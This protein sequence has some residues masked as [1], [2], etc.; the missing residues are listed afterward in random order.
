M[1]RSA[2]PL[3]AA[4]ALVAALPATAAAKKTAD[5]QFAS[6]GKATSPGAVLGVGADGTFEDFPFTIAADDQDGSVTVG[7]QW[8]N[9]ADDWDLY[10]Y[11]KN[12]SGA[13]DQV[14]SSAQGETTSE[15]AVIQAQ[16]G[17]VAAGQYVIRV[18]NYAA[19][20]PNDFTGVTKFGDFVAPNLKPTAKL[21]A[22]RRATA[23]QKVTL[24]ASGSRD[25]DGTLAHYFFDLDGDGAMETDAG[26]KAKISHRFKA[27]LH[28]VAVRVVDDRGGRAY[29]SATIAVLKAR[30]KK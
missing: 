19:S 23:G 21:K 17:P 20:N 9:V 22:P 24:S 1:R 3:L 7:I 8:T 4:L 6:S 25:L 13:L 10:V 14:A 27:G 29:A 26:T 30:K 11:K 15:E 5:F 18:Q 2:L 28:H 12:A 16:K